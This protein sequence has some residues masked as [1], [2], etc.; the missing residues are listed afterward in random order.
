MNRIEKIEAES[1]SQLILI[2]DL[3]KVI[4]HNLPSINLNH[5]LEE[6][7]ERKSSILV[8]YLLSKV[9]P[10]KLN[11]E[12]K[13]K[14]SDIDYLKDVLS[15]NNL[16]SIPIDGVLSNVFKDVEEVSKIGG[17]C[18]VGIHD[19]VG[20]IAVT[21]NE[22]L[23]IITIE[24]SNELFYKLFNIRTFEDALEDE[25]I[26]PFL[27]TCKEVDR[28]LELITNETS[29]KQK[30]LTTTLSYKELKECNAYLST[31]LKENSL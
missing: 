2:Q 1:A 3:I 27:H 29:N 10:S 24:K 18:Y 16:L 15:M 19:V 9:D 6:E 17:W 30:T 4:S 5:I 23:E 8:E 31:Y 21:I 13:H 28:K 26:K 12:F 20:S 25:M 22:K 14:I 11:T 7:K